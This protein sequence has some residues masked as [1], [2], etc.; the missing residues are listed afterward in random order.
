MSAVNS[1]SSDRDL[2]AIH[3]AQRAHEPSMEEILA[4]IRNIIARRPREGGAAQSGRNRLRRPR[5]KSSIPRT[6]PRRMATPSDCPS[7]RT[8]TPRPSSGAGRKRSKPSPP[9]DAPRAQR[10]A[11]AVARG[12]RSGRLCPSGPCRPISRF[13]APSSPTAWCATCCGRCSSSGWTTTCPPMVERLVRAE[14]QRV[15][16]GRKVGAS[17]LHVAR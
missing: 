13:A 14:I 12:E 10:G 6:P 3:R 1:N 17:A 5:R 2:E 4:S 11:V 16:R 7:A 9:R 15:A 8:R